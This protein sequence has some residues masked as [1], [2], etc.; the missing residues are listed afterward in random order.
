METVLAVVFFLVGLVLIIKGGDLFVDAASWMALVS[1]IPKFIIG[2][3]VVSVATT[4]PEIVVSVIAAAERSTEMAVG[5]AIGSVTANTGLVLGMSLVLMPLAIRRS[6]IAAKGALMIT[7]ITF[8]YLLSRDGGVSLLDGIPLFLLFTLYIVENIYQA[9][10]RESTA[11]RPKATR[12]HLGKN[13]AFFALGAGMLVLGS[14]LLVNNG[15]ILAVA[16][17]VSDRVIAVTIVAIGTSLPELVT[18][19]TAVTKKQGSLSVGNIFGANIIDITIILPLCAMVSHG[20]LPVN[21]STISIDLP[22]CLAVAAIAV[23]PTLVLKRF[24]RLQ[25]VLMAAIFIVY[26]IFTVTG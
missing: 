1:G 16:L 11:D 9:K 23:L 2:A 5:N 25:G 12:K 18:A 22:V 21:T 10:N 13:L 19:I 15:T 4:L 17:G 24:T 14:R 26:V 7:A 20:T 3:T 8:L 6:Q